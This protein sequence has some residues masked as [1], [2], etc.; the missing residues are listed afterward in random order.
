MQNQ[1]GSSS[2]ING[3]LAWQTSLPC[4]FLGMCAAVGLPCNV[5]VVVTLAFKVKKK[6]DFTK[7]LILN[8]AVCDILSLAMVP[9]II[10]FLLLG[11][12]QEDW[13]CKLFSFVMYLSLYASV[14]TVTLM[15]VHRAHVVM[16]RCPNRFQKEN[17]HKVRQTVKL[18]ALWV[19]AFVLALP[20][21]PTRNIVKK[22][23]RGEYYRC[24]I[25]TDSDSRR[26][27]ILLY[28]ILLGFFIPF[29]VLVT[30][31]CCL[32]REMRKHKAACSRQQV[33]TQRTAVMVA[34]IVVMF[35]V[36]WTPVHVISATLTFINC[37]L[38]PFLYAFALKRRSRREASEMVLSASSSS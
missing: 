6:V 1:S 3:S 5:A 25:Q 32:C 14:L 15:S 22:E 30:S 35:F 4:V 10:Y 12:L 26:V 36:F 23:G 20:I 9:A 2:S 29:V 18:I 7:K 24:Q 38:H 19:L 34:S 13:M 21:I 28:E 33:A 37:C 8:L 17:L 16:E 11:R 27:A 31:Y